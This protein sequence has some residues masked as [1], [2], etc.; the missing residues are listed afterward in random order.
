MFLFFVAEGGIIGWINSGGSLVN[1]IS[2][3]LSN[4]IRVSGRM[5]SIFV[6]DEK[7]CLCVELCDG[8]DCLEERVPDCAVECD[9]NFLNR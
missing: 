2:G 4:T 8:R 6:N 9:D 7:I 3:E 5:A 1:P